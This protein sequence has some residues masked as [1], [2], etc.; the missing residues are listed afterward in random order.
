MGHRHGGARKGTGTTVYN[1]S[2]T[3]YGE[4]AAASHDAN[5]TI[6]IRSLFFVLV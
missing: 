5:N 4:E 6:I 3:N 2:I 1:C